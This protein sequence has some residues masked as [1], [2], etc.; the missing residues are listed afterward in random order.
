M[1]L[2]GSLRRNRSSTGSRF[3]APPA[4]RTGRGPWHGGGRLVLL[5]GVVLLAGSSVGYVYATHV[6][7]PLPEGRTEEYRGV[8]DLRGMTLSEAE[9]GLREAGLLLGI[10]DSVSHP[11]R[12]RGEV[13]GQDPFPGQLAVPSGRVEVALSTGPEYRSVP[14]VLGMRPDRAVALLQ[15]SGFDV[16]VDSLEAEVPEGRV[17]LTF[18]VPG[19]EVALPAR[20]RL[21]VSL[22]PPAFPMPYLVGLDEEE[23]LLVLDSLGLE[24][25]YV[26]RRLTLIRGGE[27]LEQYPL[28]DVLVPPGAAVRIVIGRGF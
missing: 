23:A 12:V 1:R 21:T 28:S 16:A 7:F 20:V 3:G 26:G 5:L 6:A 13:V 11:W 15:T 25:A 8:P 9:A 14:D 10:V 2:G 27:V 22:G 17:A 19:A 4:S 18:P 24:V